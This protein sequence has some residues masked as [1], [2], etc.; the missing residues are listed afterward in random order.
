VSTLPPS[1]PGTFRR[2]FFYP[3]TVAKFPRSANWFA[4]MRCHRWEREM[5]RTWRPKF[6]WTN[7]CPLKFADPLASSLVME[8]AEQSITEAEIIAADTDDYPDIDVE[9]K[10]ENWGR[11]KGRVVVVDYGHWDADAIRKRRKYLKEFL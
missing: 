11:L 6:K 4:G 9:F 2:V 8:R 5:W 3:G 7:L 10:T 1:A